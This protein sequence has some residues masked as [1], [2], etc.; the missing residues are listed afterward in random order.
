MQQVLL[1]TTEFAELVRIHPNTL[2]RWV[3]LGRIGPEPIAA[4]RV[5]RWNAA[6]AEE[7]IRAGMPDRKAWSRIKPRQY[8]R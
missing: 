6:E 7:W 1:T 4:G 2:Y 3:A 5:L 8:R